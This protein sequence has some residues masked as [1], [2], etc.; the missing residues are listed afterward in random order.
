MRYS[1]G[2]FATEDALLLKPFQCIVDH[3]G[4]DDVTDLDL[5]SIGAQPPNS[6]QPAV[7]FESVRDCFVQGCRALAGTKTWA[8]V[9]GDKTARIHAVAN[10]FLRASKAFS[11]SSEV[12]QGAVSLV[13][14]D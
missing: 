12:P 1:R 14:S 6:D 4:N 8:T 11:V 9:T 7:R 2:S 10:D 5:R 13:S 3:M